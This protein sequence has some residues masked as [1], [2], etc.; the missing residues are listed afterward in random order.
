MATLI[1]ALGACVS[2]M[3]AGERRLAE[4]L[5]G[6]LDAD[7]S[8]W[9]DVPVG[10]KHSH[11]DFVVLHPS[12]GLLILETK[13]F[14]LETVPDPKETATSVSFGQCKLLRPNLGV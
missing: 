5:E 2:R 10:P 8:V 3:T 6:K 12:R 1:P 13:D 11:P 4:R 7:Y 14:K 9:Y